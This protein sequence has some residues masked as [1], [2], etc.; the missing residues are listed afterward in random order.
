MKEYI[1]S[2]CATIISMYF[3]INNNYIKNLFNFNKKQLQIQT[4]NNITKQQTSKDITKEASVMTERI[5]S[6]EEDKDFDWDI[7]EMGSV[8]YTDEIRQELEKDYES[9]LSTIDSEQVLD[10]SVVSVTDREVIV[11]INYKSD[12]V[13]SRNEFR[14]NEDLKVGDSV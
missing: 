11:N 1:F 2:S 4:S 3:I 6:S 14:Y 13:I 10:G 9:A 5:T 8:E 7:Y 12:G